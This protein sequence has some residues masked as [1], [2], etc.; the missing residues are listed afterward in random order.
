MPGSGLIAEWSVPVDRETA[1]LF[2]VLKVISRSLIV[3]ILSLLLSVSAGARSLVVG[4]TTALRDAVREALPGDTIVV[5]PGDYFL[6]N[7]RLEQNGA[8]HAPITL[9][10]AV[11]REASLW[12]G[13][14]RTIEVHGEYWQ[15]RDLDFQGFHGSGQ[16]LRLGGAADHTLIEGNL[17]RN[18]D[19]AIRV[20]A[21]EAAHRFPDN[22]SILRNVFANDTARN[23]RSAIVAIDVT[24]GRNWRIS[25]NFIADMALDRSGS[26]RSSTGILL[27][28]GAADA[29][30]D[31]NL[32]ICEWHHSGGQRMGLSLGGDGTHRG[33]FDRRGMD[34]CT[35]DCPEVRDS[36]ITN[37]VIL[38][39]PDE[40]G[41][42]LNKARDVL[43]ANNTIF[44]AFGIQ[45]RFP[46]TRVRTIDN[47]LSG[48]IWQRDNGMALSSNDLTTGWFDWANHLPAA[49]RKLEPPVAGHHVILFEWFD[50]LVRWGLGTL[51][52]LL[53]RLANSFLGKGL[54]PFETWFLAPHA[55]DFRLYD[56]PDIVSTGSSPPAVGH[57]FCGQQRMAPGDRGAF[58]YKAG[59]CDLAGELRKRHGE[60]VSTLMRQVDAPPP[61]WRAA[62]SEPRLAGALPDPLRLLDA[63]PGNV[64]QMVNGL[65]PGDWLRLAPG[66]YPGAL[67][68]HGL[69][70]TAENP[71]VISGPS[72][73][74]PA[75]LVGR[76][77][78]N[79]VS[80]LDSAYVVVRHLTLD[81]RGINISGVVAEGHGNFAHDIVLEHLRI[82]NFAA[83]PGDAAIATRLPA[84]N[85]VI[86][87]N[88]VRDVGT[89]LYLGSSDGSAPFIG[90]LI[91]NNFVADTLGY[92]AQIKHQHLRDRLPGMPTEPRQTIIRYNVFS[93]AAGSRGGVQARPNLLLGHF[94]PE[95]SGIDDRYLVYGNL[96]HENPHERLFQGEGNLVLYNNLFLNRS[97]DGLIVMRHNDVPKDVRILHNTIVAKDVGIAVVHPDRGYQQ[98]VEGNAVF[99]GEPLKLPR[100]IRSKDNFTAD[101][102]TALT[103]LTNPDAGLGDL[104][105]FPLAYSLRGGAPIDSMDDLPGLDEDYNGRPRQG[106]SWGAYGSSHL[107]NPGRIDG[108]GPQVPGCAPC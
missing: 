76:S 8:R 42:Y 37:N 2:R 61:D 55:G 59:G 20:D 71:I 93:K 45:A 44:N 23:S 94:P 67:R 80:L 68:L 11:P 10:A 46:E 70:G 81:G 57:D 15:I 48:T 5:L 74:D 41:V 28:G 103:Y 73:G 106:T 50:R 85:W 7:T 92:N 69:R 51:R 86:R 18:F 64:R 1:L 33:R 34:A 99:A 38:D 100:R 16:A 96:F 25:E 35:A 101:R 29:L 39:C 58:E 4:D 104:N 90:G 36:R 14:G 102:A 60:L 89:G 78:A 91:E 19:S 24:G 27:Q 88:H 6:P 49:K 87:N 21:K 72:T 53:D 107:T 3:V 26:E 12:L 30:I 66:E 47:V 98:V 95:G 83:G 54:A 56:G 13:Q 108:V 22:V 40:P 31:R 17:F 65:Q 32:I 84:W 9:R 52:G 62:G 97:G 75:V 63:N 43:I 79:V 82:H 105:L 77:G